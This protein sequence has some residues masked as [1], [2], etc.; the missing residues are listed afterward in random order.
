MNSNA[1]K[2]AALALILLS[3]PITARAT[4]LTL[5]ISNAVKTVMEDLVP[6]FETATGVSASPGAFPQSSAPGPRSLRPLPGGT[7]WPRAL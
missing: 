7:R 1:A 2:A 4:E 5:L 6:R 3:A